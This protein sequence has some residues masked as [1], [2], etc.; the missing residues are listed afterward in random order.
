MACRPTLAVPRPQAAEY[1]AYW[2]DVQ[3]ASFCSAL[4]LPRLPYREFA[5]Q[6]TKRGP[7]WWEHALQ[8]CDITQVPSVEDYR[9]LLASSHPEEFDGPQRYFHYIRVYKGDRKQLLRQLGGVPNTA[10]YESALCL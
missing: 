10:W 7:L 1:L 5:V 3:Y 2:G 8:L 4:G 6:T 9:L